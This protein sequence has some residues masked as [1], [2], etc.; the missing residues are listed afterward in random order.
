M[1]QMS[2]VQPQCVVLQGVALGLC[3]GG[4]RKRVYIYI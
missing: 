1:L 2:A 4:V 3:G